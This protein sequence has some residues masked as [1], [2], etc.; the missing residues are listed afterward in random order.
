[1]RGKT[2]EALLQYEIGASR[3]KGAKDNIS[4]NEITP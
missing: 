2:I 1:M 3:N 4:V